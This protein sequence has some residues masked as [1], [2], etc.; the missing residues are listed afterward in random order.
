MLLDGRYKSSD[1][2]EVHRPLFT[3]ECP[4][5]LLFQFHHPEIPF[6]LII[7]E[8][9]GEIL[10]EC[11]DLVLVVATAVQEVLRFR[12]LFSA[13]FSRFL[14]NSGGFRFLLPRFENPAI[15]LFKGGTSLR[16]QDRSL[17]FCDIHS[18]FHIEQEVAQSFAPL[19][20]IVLRDPAEFAQKMGVTD[21]MITGIPEVGSPE[22][23]D[24]RPP[25]RGQNP[26]GI[27]CLRSAFPM[28]PVAGEE[29]GTGDMQPV[30]GAIYPHTG[31][32]DMKNLCPLQEFPDAFFDP[33]QV[34]GALAHGC[35]HG[36]LAQRVAEEVKNHFRGPII[37][38][39]LVDAE[40]DE[41]GLQGDAVLHG[42]RHLGRKGSLMGTPTVGTPFVFGTVFG[43]DN[44]GGEYQ[45]PD[46]VPHQTVRRLPGMFHRWDRRKLYGR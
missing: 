34:L 24:H 28:V 20:P 3:S 12:L 6:G 4:G 19:M 16:R 40:V 35:D 43:H 25:K 29:V 8:G 45:K 18:C 41:E 17:L 42:M 13:A 26:H 30:P 46:A 21:R 32:I 10:H 44:L 14:G 1:S 39:Q 31:F 9:D 23:M 37:R 36:C 11:Q 5:D 15:P 7:G 2:A 33:G 27:G 22:V 38:Q